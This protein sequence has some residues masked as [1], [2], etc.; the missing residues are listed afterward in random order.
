MRSYVLQKTSL[1][2]QSLTKS[3]ISAF[4]AQRRYCCTLLSSLTWVFL[5]PI[6]YAERITIPQANILYIEP[7][8]FTRRGAVPTAAST[9]TVI[10]YDRKTENG[11]YYFH[12][13]YQNFSNK[14]ES[15]RGFKKVYESSS[16]GTNNKQSKIGEWE[17]FYNQFY[18]S[19]PKDSGIK[20]EHKRLFA[21]Y[22]NEKAGLTLTV[23]ST[24][25]G[26]KA[27][28]VRLF[29][30]FLEGLE[31]K[32]GA[33]QAGAGQPATRPELKLEGSNKPQ[34]EAEGRSR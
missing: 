1:P 20:K 10:A 19:S 25:S 17:L 3:I 24:N 13:Y 31:P 7:D 30:E 23:T 22:Q 18:F 27:D 29:N 6:A 8:D 14:K 34:P 2:M 15:E 4:L 16:K 12:I 11:D 9:R 32:I 28:L 33:E 21:F 5:T 26:T